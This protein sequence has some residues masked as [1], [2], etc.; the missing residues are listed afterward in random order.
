MRSCLI[1]PLLAAT[2]IAQPPNMP[3]PTI[4][5]GPADWRF[6]KMPTPPGFAP[7]IKLNK[8]KNLAGQLNP[9]VPLPALM[10]LAG[11]DPTKIRW[12]I[13]SHVHLDHIVGLTFLTDTLSAC[14]EER[15]VTVTGR[16]MT[17]PPRGRPR[18]ACPARRW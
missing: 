16:V 12:V 18:R 9:E 6:E 11:A 4:L 2:A 3:P 10:S 14:G 1:I 5:K 13:L 7:D 17:V 15:S 8:S